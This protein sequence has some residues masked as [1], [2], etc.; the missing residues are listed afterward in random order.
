MR[1]PVARALSTA[2]LLALCGFLTAP[3]AAQG[4]QRRTVS[5]LP[6][7]DYSVRSVCAVPAPGHAG[8]LALELVGQTPAARAHTHPLGMARSAPL[9]AS[10]ATEPCESP[11]A[12]EGCYGLRP[13]DLHSAYG[14]P[15]TAS[16]AQTIALVDAYDD[17]HA[18]ADLKVYDEEFHLSSCTTANGCFTKVNEQGQTSPLPATEGG[19]AEEIS[20]DI[21][22]AH[23]TCQNCHILLVEAS[24]SSYTSLDAAEETAVKLGAAEISNS[25]SGGEPSTDSPVFN[26][27]GIVIAAAAGDDGY[28]NWQSQEL[29]TRGSV[30]YP[31]SSPHVVAVGGTRL[32]FTT[33]GAWAGE[34]VWNGDGATGGGC[35]E[36][37]GAPPWQRGLSG[38]SAVG[39]ESKRAVADVSADADPYTGVAVYDSTPVQTESGKRVLGW[40]PIGGTSLASPLIASAFALGG[41][42]GGVEYPAETLYENQLKSPASLH[43]VQSGSNGECSEPFNDET[44]LSGCTALEEAQSSCSGKPIC[45]A[46]LGYD[47]PS[48]VGTPHGLGVFQPSSQPIKETQTIEFTSSAPGSA[49]VGGP[50]YAVTATASSGLAVSLSSGTPSVCS[51]SGSTVSFLAAGTC[52]IDASQAGNSEYDSAPQ[53]QQS[54]VVSKGSQ[55]ITFSSSAPGAATVGGPTYTVVATASSGLLVSFSSGTP[56][57][58]SLEGSTVSFLGAG[59]CTIDA[60]QAGNSKYKAAPQVQQS[61][62]VRERSQA[63]A[64]TSSAPGSATVGGPTYAVTAAASSG[65]AVS[66][67]SGTPS[68]CSLSGSTVSFLA[69]GTCTIDANQAGNSVY[70]AALEAQQTFVV[71]RRSQLIAFLSTAPVSASVGEATYAVSATASSGLAVVLSS[72]TPSVCS[73]EGSA[74]SFIAPGMCSISAAQPGNAEY[75]AAPQMQQSFTVSSA[76]VLAFTPPLTYPSPSTS[77]PTFPSTSPAPVT[78]MPALTSALMPPYTPMAD[79]SFSLLGNPSISRRTGAI[80]FKVSVSDPGTFSWLL[81]FPNSKFGAFSVSKA[82]CN[83]GQVR[84]KG[85]CFQ[86]KVVFAGGGT[87]VAAAGTMSFVIKPRVSARSALEAALKQDRGLSVTATLTFQSSLGGLPVSQTRSIVVALKQTSKKGKG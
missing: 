81:T 51:L 72:T 68:V 73:L 66:L 75:D 59:T 20:L 36:H 77:P 11:S 65:L 76:P 49:T 45:L 79:S 29:E 10:K 64:F 4:N 6:A 2:A 58:C 40:V 8:C 13:Q 24:D 27:P 78:S 25:W 56:S 48:G 46:G 5:P 41:G 9:T 55:L 3:A 19:W 18:E 84:L 47:G 63:I 54:F 26:H 53:A 61:F 86:A 57:V 33:G 31:A 38:W 83:T 44:G 7:S 15:T 82:K 1:L 52:T 71:S 17:P 85:K 22:V 32:S 23:G 37:F 62:A 39:C 43:D 50:T 42:A 34:T 35:S 12:A 80:V 28:L 16:S 60:N 87:T 67:S 30:G 70:D 69:A 14:L 74:V 21:E